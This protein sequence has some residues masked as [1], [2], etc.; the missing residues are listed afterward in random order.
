VVI[1]GTCIK[2]TRLRPT[3]VCRRLEA[4][5]PKTAG[6][7][8]ATYLEAKAARREGATGPS[9][10][11]CPG[12]AACVTIPIVAW[13]PQALLAS[14]MPLSIPER[15]GVREGQ[16]TAT[17][18]SSQTLLCHFVAQPGGAMRESLSI[19]LPGGYGRK[20]T[21]T[22]RLPGS[23][24]ATWCGKPFGSTS[25]GDGSGHCERNSLLT[26]RP[27][28]FTPKTTCS[29]KSLEGASGHQGPRGGLSQPRRMPRAGGALLLEPRGRCLRKDSGG[30]GK[31]AGP[32]G[33]DS[34]A[35]GR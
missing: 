31:D 29:G 33:Q 23:P 27:P 7:V 16:P 15:G 6:R 3:R 10:G 5:L 26:V 24:G 12:N 35:P 17:L 21:G 25:S 34:A 14:P 22:P 4:A 20:L 9:L 2:P 28:V 13:T 1:R 8:H 11:S 19:S 32:E 30:V 18:L